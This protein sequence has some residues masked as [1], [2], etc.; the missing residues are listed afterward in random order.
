MR[1][2]YQYVLI[3]KY[4]KQGHLIKQNCIG[5]YDNVKEVQRCLIRYNHYLKEQPDPYFGNVK[6]L[7]GCFVD[8]GL[9]T[10]YRDKRIKMRWYRIK[11]FIF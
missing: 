10:W 8:N 2:I 5:Y 3:K 11:V 4:Y 9:D 7:Y 6:K 1:A